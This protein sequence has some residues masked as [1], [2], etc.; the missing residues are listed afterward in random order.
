MQGL[1]DGERMSFPGGGCDPSATSELSR[2]EGPPSP[3]GA[4][5]ANCGNRTERP[6]DSH[7]FFIYPLLF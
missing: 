2:A 1:W 4:G 7:A 6:L 5:T 3:R